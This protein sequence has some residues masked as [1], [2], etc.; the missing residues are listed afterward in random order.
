MNDNDQPYKRS[1]WDVDKR[2]SIDIA[3][4]SKEMQEKI[5]VVQSVESAKKR[6]PPIPISDIVKIINAVENLPSPAQITV[7]KF[8]T[9][10][11]KI[12]S[13]W[14]CGIKTSICILSVLKHGK[15]PPLDERIARAAKKKR[16]IT[17][18]EEKILN[19]KNK[20]KIASIYVNKI[21]ESWLKD[22]KEVKDPKKLDNKWGKLANG[23]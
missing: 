8:T 16:I 19:G 5:A 23:I 11:D 2:Y 7:K 10:L 6:T 9:C 4:L 17:E 21:L 18:D 14:G 13:W 20:S 3:N 15:Y 22:L 1:I 12:D